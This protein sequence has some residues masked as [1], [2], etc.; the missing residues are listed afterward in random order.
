MVGTLNYT[1]QMSQCIFSSGQLIFTTF[2]K[3]LMVQRSLQNAR[4]F[5]KNTSF[6]VGRNITKGAVTQGTF[7][8]NCLTRN[9]VATQVT[10]KILR[11]TPEIN[12]SYNVFAAATVAATRSRMQQKRHEKCSTSGDGK[13]SN[14][15]YETLPVVL[16]T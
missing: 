14:K 1:R 9:F 4:L 2:T 11:V 8:A 15:L 12:M 16:A 13:L 6:S 10:R 7:H 5:T 3:P